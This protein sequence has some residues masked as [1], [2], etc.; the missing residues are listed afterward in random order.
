[1]TSAPPRFSNE[2]VG[3][4]PRKFLWQ[5][6]SSLH[7]DTG[8][9]NRTLYLWHHLFGLLSRCMLIENQLLALCSPMGNGL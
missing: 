5:L 2:R 9:Y 3:T 1:M 8:R 6:R 7:V 4:S